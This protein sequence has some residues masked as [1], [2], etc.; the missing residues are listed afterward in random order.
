MPIQQ[1]TEILGE[2][3]A[4][5]YPEQLTELRIACNFI[6]SKIIQEDWNYLSIAPGES[7]NYNKE[8]FSKEKRD[9]HFTEEYLKTNQK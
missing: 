4:E 6:K 1:T 5:R 3:F 2:R 8:K 7:Q 9:E